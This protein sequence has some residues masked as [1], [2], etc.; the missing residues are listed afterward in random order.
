MIPCLIIGGNQIKFKK[1]ASFSN[2]LSSFLNVSI[3][4]MF[5]INCLRTVIRNEKSRKYK[6]L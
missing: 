6:G 2:A 3:K 5:L 4:L 1:H